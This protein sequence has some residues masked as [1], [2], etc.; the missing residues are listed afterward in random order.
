MFW[1]EEVALVEIMGKVGV[2]REFLEVEAAELVKMDLQEGP[3]QLAK[4][5]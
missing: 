1:E 3:G 4:L 2:T 5:L